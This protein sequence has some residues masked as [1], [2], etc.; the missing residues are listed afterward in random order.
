MRESGAK[1]SQMQGCGLGSLLAYGLVVLSAGLFRSRAYALFRAVG[2]GLHTAF[3]LALAPSLWRVW[4]LF[5][6]LHATVYVHSL[7]LVRPRLR[8]LWYRALISVPAA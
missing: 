2:L 8:P 4:P 7:L 3:A 1:T 5:V 6:Y